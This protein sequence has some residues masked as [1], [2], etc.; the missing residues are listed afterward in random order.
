[1]D[2]GLPLPPFSS[3]NATPSGLLDDNIVSNPPSPDLEFYE[4][5]LP[6]PLPLTQSGR[7]RR[8]YRLPQRFCDNLPEPLAPAPP[9]LDPDPPRVRRV[10]LIVRDRVITG[11]NSF[12][13]WRDYPE[14][15][16]FD[17]DS[18]LTIEDFCHQRLSLPRQ[19]IP[20]STMQMLP[21]SRSIHWPFSNSTIHAVM[22]WLNNGKTAKSEAETTNFV[23]DVILTPTFNRD[24]L[25]GFD[26]HRENQRLDK[27][28][29]ESAPH[30][31]FIPS[32]VEIL[33]P[34][35]QPQ[36]DPVKYVVPGL[37]YRKLVDVIS[38]AFNNPLAHL[39]HYSPFKLF[40]KNPTTGNDERIYGEIYTSDAF[41]E[42]TEK[43]H[44]R[45]PPAPDDPDCKREKAV[46]ALMFSSD[47][48]HLTDF[49]NAKGWPIYLMLGNL[50][51]YV[52]SL[53]NSGG[54]HHLAYIPSVCSY[55]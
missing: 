23:H 39:L 18:W 14:R 11:L 34:S 12:G 49:G 24:D 8:K 5:P 32:K 47:A 4:A 13:I 17:P 7:P 21:H 1:M 9:V 30:T 52:R 29:S 38:D 35:G 28:L 27:A 42:E 37:L 51:K 15:P 26:A 22:Q 31:Q 36:V 40:H 48:T 2:P 3:S 50:S 44:R 54:M 55:F 10:L 46:A 41:L 53:P 6:S 33:V 25:V 45:S 43:V 19:P 16:T 20:T